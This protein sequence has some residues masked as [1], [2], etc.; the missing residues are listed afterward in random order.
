MRRL[1]VLALFLL[2]GIGAAAAR[3]ETA[4]Q[5]REIRVGDRLTLTVT[6]VPEPG[7]RPLPFQPPA[8]LSP[9]ELLTLSSTGSV[10][11]LTL[12]T[13]EVD[14]ATLPALTFS[15]MNAAGNTLSLQTP[16]IPVPIVS[17]LPKDAKGL[18]GMKGRLADLPWDPRPWLAGA[19]IGVAV[20]GLFLW[21]RSRKRKSL[22]AGPPPLP[23][24]VEALRSLEALEDLLG[25]PAKPYYS[26]LTDALRL[27][28]VRRFNL[29]ALDRTTTEL[30]PLLKEL[31]ISL[32]LRS[33]LRN[34]LETADLAKFA[35]FESPV[36]ERLRHRDRAR[37]LVESTRPAAE[38][39]PPQ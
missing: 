26:G 38:P 31:P 16:E 11:V 30:V 27:Y 19:A 21:W 17:V 23:P 4:V 34:L 12:T 9:F 22:S 2:S 3:I 28:M 24:D 14:T 1:P 15:Y 6:L 37:E 33:A 8:D 36:D 25:G 10:H 20:V 7:E 18:K 35:R 39:E 5:P 32:T 13:F 29:P